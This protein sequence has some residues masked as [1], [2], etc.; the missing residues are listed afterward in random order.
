MINFLWKSETHRWPALYTVML[1]RTKAWN[2]EFVAFLRAIVR[3]GEPFADFQSGVDMIYW[4]LF[5]SH[6][7]DKRKIDEAVIIAALALFRNNGADV[8]F[9][10]ERNMT[11]LHMAV[12]RNFRSVAKWLVDNGANIEAK[13][14]GMHDY[15][16]RTPLQLAIHFLHIKMV[17]FLLRCGAKRDYATKF[18]LSDGDQ[19]LHCAHSLHY[20][21][22]MER[23]LEL[24]RKKRFAARLLY[25]EAQITH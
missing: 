10:G 20:K 19:S 23:E 13:T 18:V 5:V 4:T 17:D 25:F 11:A 24:S 22:K 8:N 3:C 16:L 7:H 2:A 6:G 14:V 15:I 9:V 1:T 12:Q 21:I